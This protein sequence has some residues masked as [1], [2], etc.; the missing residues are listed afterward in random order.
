MKQLR[1][2]LILLLIMYS[3]NLFSQPQRQIG[4]RTG[5]RSGI[6]FQISDEIGNTETGYAAIL[7][8]NNGI[9]ITGLRILYKDNLTEISDELF[10]SLGYGGHAGLIFTDHYAFLGEDYYFKGQRTLPVLGADGWIS[11]EY[12]FREIPLNISLNVKPFVELTVPSFV[13]IVPIDLGLTVTY[14]F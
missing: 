2:L 9:H 5:V 1:T 8:L 11:A 6:F 14:V 7:G 3:G 13:R 4:L 12:R 10:L